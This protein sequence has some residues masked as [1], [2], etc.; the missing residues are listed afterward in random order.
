M[1]SKLDRFNYHQAIDLI[2]R[3]LDAARRVREEIVPGTKSI[4]ESAG[5]SCV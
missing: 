1:F 3:E 2:S 5:E 4:I